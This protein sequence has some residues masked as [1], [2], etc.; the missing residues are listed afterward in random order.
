M[1]L[2]RVLAAAAVTGCTAIALAPHGDADP[3]RETFTIGFRYHADKSALDNYLAFANQA[4]RA[5]RIPGGR[6]IE[7]GRVDR[8]CAENLLEQVVT[9][10]ERPQL[11]SIHET[12][13]GVRADSSRTLAAR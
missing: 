13:T 10:M 6:G 9:R 2:M 11:A 5:C 7:M 3:A 1:F 4:A 8:A 12:R